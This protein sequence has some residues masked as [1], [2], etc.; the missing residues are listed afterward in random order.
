[1]NQYCDEF[2]DIYELAAES[3]YSHPDLVLK[4]ANPTFYQNTF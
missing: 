1:M 3:F 4:S 2:K